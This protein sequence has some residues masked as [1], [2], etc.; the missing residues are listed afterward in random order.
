MHEIRKSSVNVNGR[1][2]EIFIRLVEEP[3]VTLK[4][5]AGSTGYTGEDDRE[6]SGRTYVSLFCC[7]GD[8]CFHPIKDKHGRVVG[9]EIAACGDDAL[10][11]LVHSFEF[12]RQAL[13]DSRYLSCT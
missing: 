3:E 5:E 12:A 2:V 7:S 11:G 4:V 10:D 8:F 13:E 9:M 1:E 6:I